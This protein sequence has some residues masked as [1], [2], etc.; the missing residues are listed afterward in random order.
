MEWGLVNQMRLKR[1]DLS[2]ISLLEEVPPP[3]FHNPG[4]LDVSEHA[5]IADLP[6]MSQDSKDNHSQSL[7]HE[8]QDR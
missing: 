1:Q 6:F 3:Q 7:D 5:P 4:H 8:R 2:L